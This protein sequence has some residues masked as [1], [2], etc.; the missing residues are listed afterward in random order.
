MTGPHLILY[1]GVCGLCNRVTQFVL[2]WDRD[3]VFKF[4]SI[5]SPRGQEIITSFGANPADLDTF[6]VVAGFDGT[7][8]ALL[9]KSTGALFVLRELGGIWSV[10]AWA[11]VLPAALRD[12]AYDLVA[13]HRYRMFGKYDVCPVPSPEHRARF[14]A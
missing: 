4:V 6:Y 5:Q 12:L 13:K 10:L 8:P 2:R 14:L 11:R 1:D 7:Q 9:S 3:G